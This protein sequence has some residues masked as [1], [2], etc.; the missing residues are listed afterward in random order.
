MSDSDSIVDLLVFGGGMAGMSAAA[1]ACSDGA[2]VVLVEKGPA[3]GGSAMYAGFIW[4][5][6]TV[7]VMREVNPDGDPALSAEVVEHYGDALDWVRSLGVHVADPVTVLGYGRGSQTDMANYLL[8][9]DRLV[10]ERGEVLVGWSAQRL[11]FEDGAVVGAEI[12]N[13]SG[14]RRVIRAR[15]TLLATGGFGGDPGAARRAHPSAGGQPAAAGEPEQRRR[16]PS[17]RPVG[18]RRLRTAERRL[19]RPPDPV[20]GRLQQPLRVHR[21]HLL[22]LRARRPAQPGG[23][24]VLRRDDRR[25]PEHA[26]RARPAGGARAARL[27]PARPRRV[28]DGALRR[29]RRAARQVPA[30]LPPRRPRGGGGRDRG[31]RGAAGGMGLSGRGLSRHPARV[32]PPMRGRRADPGPQARRRAARHPSRTTS[33]R[34]S[35]RSR[36]RSAG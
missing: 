23:Q 21:S 10:R 32:Q 24:A 27:R 1:R 36:S 12:E 8:A 3:I 9:C 18:G 28:D 19:L 4:T 35:P 25:S 20:E 34:S 2:S 29:G 7:E 31:V 14:E 17:A 33:S 26:L 6:P 11:L 15:S 5:A 16:R 30:R 22:P 13:G